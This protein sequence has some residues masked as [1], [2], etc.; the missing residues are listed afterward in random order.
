MVV[1]LFLITGLVGTWMT[2]ADP[3]AVDLTAARA[4]PSGSHLLGTDQLGRD[5]LSRLIAGARGSALAVVLVLSVS[6]LV[7]SLFGVIAGWQGGVVDRTMLRLIDVVTG[8]PA[9]LL[10]LVLAGLLGGSS[11]DVGL[12]LAATS[13]PPYVRVIRT[14]T[15]LRRD[16]P[17]NQALILLGASPRHILL[18][19]VL[20]AL[21]GP[22]TVLLGVSTAE[23]ILSVATLSFLGLGARPPTPE[24]GSM[25]VESQPYLLSAPWLFLAPALALTLVAASCTVLAERAGRW[26]THGTLAHLPRLTASAPSSDQRVSRLNPAD[27][28]AP[29][30]DVR[31]LTVELVSANGAARVVDSVSFSVASGQTLAIVGPS[32][33]GK[34]MAMLGVL[35]LFPPTVTASVTGSV[36]VSGR[37]LIDLPEQELR[38]IRGGT[39]AYVPQDLGTALNP[40][41]RVGAQVAAVARNHQVLDRR[42]ARQRALELLAKVGLPDAERVSLARPGELSGGMR[43]RVLLAAALAGGPDLLI[44]DE[45]TSA[46]DATTAVELVQLLQQLQDQLG[47]AL[48]IVTHELGVAA[49]LASRIAVFDHGQI[50][51]QSDLPALLVDAQHPTIRRLLAA[52]SLPAFSDEGL[53]TRPVPAAGQQRP[54]LLEVRGLRVEYPQ[55]G[56]RRSVLAVDGV[57]LD[58]R[59]GEVLGVVGNSGCGKSS[60]ARALVGI[61]PRTR[62]S[63][64]LGGH[65]VRARDG[66]GQLVFQDPTTA[67]DRRQTI[68]AAVAE[69]LRLSQRPTADVSARTRALLERVG[70][71]PQHATRRPWQLSGGEQQRAVIA[72]CLAGNPELL[73]LDEPVS[74]LDAVRRLG[75]VRLLASLRDEGLALILISHD[76]GVV[77][78]LADRV[79]I[80]HNGRV[81]EVLSTQRPAGPSRHA[82]T[83]ELARARTFFSLA[84]A[85]DLY[86]MRGEVP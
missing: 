6:L 63:V 39:V 20:P 51:E 27:P 85:I 70:L 38:K 79:M 78:Q 11:L 10:G 49:R 59:A 4:A 42:A 58:L 13:W 17:S 33:S 54:P 2:P 52:A 12:A 31:N 30:L 57:D 7:G 32:G 34:T 25:L 50:V 21:S 22:V 76:L 64:R 5:E 46:L 86:P 53:F 18:R 72:R 26:F 24:W 68:G 65:P 23:V 84:P 60:L 66:R 77:E 37:N 74:S 81:V 56:R 9:L 19:H 48:V 1:V 55:R 83:R 47:L 8:I 40:L 44:A 61:E 16:N 15:R 45:P 36:Q 28:L 75:I 73:V 14:E 62:G 69:A 80:M 82:A 71:S 35:G 3:T 43:Q 67:L 41:Q 29:V